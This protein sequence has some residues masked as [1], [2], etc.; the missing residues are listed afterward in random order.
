[1]TY[2]HKSFAQSEVLLEFEKIAAGKAFMDDGTPVSQYKGDG[3]QNT[4][5]SEISAIEDYI[6]DLYTWVFT[7]VGQIPTPVGN[8]LAYPGL[9]ES[10]QREDWLNTFFFFIAMTP[11]GVAFL[12]AVKYLKNPAA[13]TA[14]AVAIKFLRRFGAKSWIISKTKSLFKAMFFTKSWKNAV[15]DFIFRI[16]LHAPQLLEIYEKQ[17]KIKRDEKALKQYNKHISEIEAAYREGKARELAGKVVQA[18]EA[19]I[20]ALG[21][22]LSQHFE[23]NGI[24]FILEK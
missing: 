7:T 18:G 12:G 15:Y 10:I 24:G 6:N 17:D 11:G 16:L 21:N 4:Q 23:K 9:I 8:P 20:D 2:R 5:Q 14:L 3:F 22:A 1:M 13:R 19:D